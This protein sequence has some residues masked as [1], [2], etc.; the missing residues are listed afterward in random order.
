MYNVKFRHLHH[1]YNVKHSLIML[2]QRKI[3]WVYLLIKS[4]MKELVYSSL[5]KMGLKFLKMKECHDSN[6]T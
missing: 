6:P 2:S 5:K 4:L 1:I 3:L